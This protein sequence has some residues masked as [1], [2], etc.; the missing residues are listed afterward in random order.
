MNR[1]INEDL[2]YASPQF[3]IKKGAFYLLLPVKDVQETVSLKSDLSVGVDLGVS[4]PAYVALSKGKAHKAIGSIDDFLRVRLQMQRRRKKLQVGMMNTAGGHG[5]KK[6]LAAGKILSDKERNFAK[7]YN[8]MISRRVV[9]F[10]IKHKAGTIK[11]E[12]LKG[13]GRGGDEAKEEEQKFILRNWSFFELQTMI[14]YKAKRAGID[15]IMIDP[16]HTSQICSSCE[17][18]ESGQRLGR[19]F[20]CKSCGSKLNAD[21]NAAINISQSTT[22]PSQ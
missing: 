9:D 19:E 18:F 8:H 11:L 15:V 1:V 4:V 14:T 12:S 10:A 17:H 5:C 22:L 16:Y 3:Q 21:H 13:F 7:T 20:I 2:E 6:K